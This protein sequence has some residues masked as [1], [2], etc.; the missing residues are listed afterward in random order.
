MQLSISQEEIDFFKHKSEKNLN[1]FKKLKL[2]IN[3]TYS[4][5]VNW[6]ETI[7]D[8]TF[9]NEE[10]YR[11]CLNFFP[12]HWI[13]SRL[14]NSDLQIHIFDDQLLGLEDSFWNDEN[15]DCS[16]YKNP[17]NS[18]TSLQRDFFAK[19]NGNQ[20]YAVCKNELTDGFFNLMRYILPITWI[21]NNKFLIHSSSCLLYTSP[22]P[23]DRQKSRMPSSA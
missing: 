8:F 20:V 16:I 15:Y 4:F 5:K 11:L 19:K 6:H 1:P 21:K 18:E 13:L 10:F 14:D 2:P 3:L 23:R 17:N 9:Q 22:S 12:Q 7:I